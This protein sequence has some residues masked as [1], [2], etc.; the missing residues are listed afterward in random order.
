[1]GYVAVRG[2]A[3][4]IEASIERLRFE[5]VRGGVVARPDQVREGMRRLVEQVMS[6]GSLYDEEAATCAVAQAEGSPEEA[7]FLL[8]AY[9][10]T[11]ARTH[12]SREIRSESMRIERRI[13][14][15]FKDIP[16]GQ[17][18]GA[19]PDYTHRLLDPRLF[20]EGDSE[21]RRW[22]REYLKRM[23]GPGCIGS[24]PKVVDFLREEGLVAPCSAPEE[25]PRD[26]T[27]ALLVF[28]ATRSERLQTM[29]RGQTGAV[30]AFAYAALRGYGALHPTVAELRVGYLPVHVPDPYGEDSPEDAYYAGEILVTE[31]EM[32]VPVSVPRG[33]GKAD[34]IFE[35]GYGMCFG[36]NETKAIAMSIL[37]HSLETGDRRYP[38]GD[39]EFVLTH[40]DTVEATGFISHLKLPH[41]V[42]F[43]SKL[44]AVRAA[45]RGNE[46]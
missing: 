22:V 25:P 37:D 45:R 35:L 46:E 32:L 40:I 29:A 31:V 8:R 26:V 16:G 9:R 19:S 10:S 13:S 28:P 3:Q 24:L 11:L 43:Q 38:P 39:E 44:D 27:R 15:A 34:L 4:A 23:P 20:Q 14:A 6:E 30:T 2:G 36:K 33:Q 5:R 21:A 1:V 17:I 7:V 42:T 41:Y 12:T 18:L